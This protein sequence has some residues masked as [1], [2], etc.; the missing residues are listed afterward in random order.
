MRKWI[1][2][3]FLASALAQAATPTLINFLSSFSTCKA[4]PSVVLWTGTVFVCPALGVGITYN[5]AANTVTASSP[6]YTPVWAIETVGFSSLAVGATQLTYTTLHTP[7]AGVILYWYSSQNLFTS[8]FGS[9][10]FTGQPVT[11]T[12]PTGWLSTDSVTFVYASQ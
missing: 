7:I 6:A 1:L 4:G 2:T 8:T 3:L 11:I 9:V 12:L 5:S 10:A